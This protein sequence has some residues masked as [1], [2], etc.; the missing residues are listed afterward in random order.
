MGF[1]I[2]IKRVKI[3]YNYILFRSDSEALMKIIRLIANLLTV[4]EI[5]ND[6]VIKKGIYYK[7]LVKKLKMLLTKK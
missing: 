7:D 6:I 4:E 3:K 1:Q 2:I 5:G